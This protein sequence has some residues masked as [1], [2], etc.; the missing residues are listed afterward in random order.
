MGPNNR[1]F[2]HSV[3]KPLHPRTVPSKSID[4]D[5]SFDNNITPFTRKIVV[6]NVEN[7]AVIVK[8]V[9]D[10]YV[11]MC[12]YDR[13]VIDD[14]I[15]WTNNIHVI[16][17][18]SPYYGYGDLWN[19]QNLF[20]QSV[21]AANTENVSLL[22]AGCDVWTPNGWVHKS[23]DRNATSIGASKD[24]PFI[25]DLL[26]VALESSALGDWLL[27]INSDCIISEDLYSDLINTTGC[28]VEYMRR[29][30]CPN[31]SVYRDVFNAHNCLFDIGI[32]GIAIRSEYYKE[33]RDLL[34]DMLI[35]EPHWDTVFHGFFRKNIPTILV[36]DKLYHL[37]HEQTW[38]GDEKSEGEVYNERIFNDA[39][40]YGLID[41]TIITPETN[42]TDTA[43]VVVFFGNDTLRC[44]STLRAFKEQRK[45]DLYCDFY[46]VELL[47]GDE[48][49]NYPSEILNYVNHVVV[50]GNKDCK[51]LWQKECLMN[52]GWYH[53]NK[54]GDYKYFIFVDS[55]IYSPRYDWFR[56]IRR[57]L[58]D[59]HMNVVQGFRVVEDTE[60]LR[61]NF[62]SLASCH[63]LNDQTD[64][65]INP[66]MC[67]GVS[68]DV[69]ER[70][71]GFN[72]YFIDGGGDSG[73]VA[74]YLNTDEYCYDDSQSDFDWFHE[75]VRRQKVRTKIDCVPH[76]IV[77]VNHG[78]FT[79]KNYTT[80]RYA[81][82]LFNKRILQLIKLNESGLLE[83]ID[84]SCIERKIMNKR[85]E[86][87]TKED[88]EKIFN[89]Y[90]YRW[91]RS[92]R[93]VKH[94]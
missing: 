44:E 63:V 55:D 92:K 15:E 48:E 90:N 9:N 89:Y 81:M 11:D 68:K 30:I 49:S 50:R 62:S 21:K 32:D 8:T 85:S 65:S 2:K 43:V 35:G 47:I 80:I 93:D 69:L 33:I 14:K 41:K 38:G 75:I 6:N 20:L 25:K 40:D 79:N 66:G 39:V 53:A 86:M 76:D 72:P 28:V 5:T 22:S 83:W 18:M 45:Q 27:Y 23:L 7:H 16:H 17:I 42:A 12:G 29:D 56:S 34:P 31:I 1:I 37:K 36:T 4:T 91:D 82:H 59:D 78:M 19:R 3:Y 51:D 74:E 10:E 73:F 60:D 70:G 64:L 58:Y 77:H 46:F 84:G 87:F 26:D 13:S 54:C 61:L 24:K 88:V 94:I 71:N 67:W 57:K 52:H